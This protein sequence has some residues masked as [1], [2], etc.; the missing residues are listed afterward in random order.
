MTTARCSAAIGLEQLER[1]LH[2]GDERPPADRLVAVRVGHR[3]VRQILFGDVD[4]GD[5][6]VARRP[7]RQVREHGVDRRRQA[8]GEERRHA[9]R[10]Q[11][12]DG[13]PVPAADRPVAP[14]VLD[15]LVG[16]QAA[17]V[18]VEGDEDRAQVAV[19]REPVAHPEQRVHEPAEAQRPRVL[20]DRL[21]HRRVAVD[22]DD[23]EVGFDVAQP[24]LG[25]RALAQPFEQG[26]EILAP[27][28]AHALVA[29][30]VAERGDALDMVADVGRGAAGG[31]MAVVHDRER[32]A[33]AGGRGRGRRVAVGGDPRPHPLDV[34]L[35]A[36]PRVRVLARVALED[37]EQPPR[38]V[39]GAVAED[40]PEHVEPG[41]RPHVGRVV[42]R[43][44]A[45]LREHLVGR[46]GQAGADVLGRREPR[47]RLARDGA[48]LVP[49]QLQVALAVG[50]DPARQAAQHLGLGLRSQRLRDRARGVGLV[51]RPAASAP[52]RS[53]PG[54]AGARARARAAATLAAAAPRERRRRRPAPRRRAPGAG[55]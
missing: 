7:L 52:A 21:V 24:P 22:G 41:L 26:D 49:G 19:Q 37:L 9:D 31:R 10:Q 17:L 29:D 8:A 43:Q 12:V 2:V 42:G 23:L 33:A 15:R 13:V 34:R 28:Q 20:G 3:A 46:D 54:R 14:Q 32:A 39:V 53:A 44:G 36:L 11:Q 4:V 16:E 48:Q 30:E 35:G 6:R 25:P 5:R 27:V 18:A 51:G 45:E 50:H 40:G 55:P 47:P 38:K 1:A